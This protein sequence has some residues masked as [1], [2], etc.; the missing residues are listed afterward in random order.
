MPIS[1]LDACRISLGHTR[2]LLRVVRRHWSNPTDVMLYGVHLRLDSEWAT[3]PV[4]G[5]IYDGTYECDE[6]AIVSDTVERDDCVIELGCGSG[7]ISALAARRTANPVSCYDADPA[8]VRVARETLR[9]N[10]AQGTVVNAVM[11]REPAVT[12]TSFYVHRDFWS[13]SLVAVHPGREITVPV[14]DL[15]AVIDEHAAS[16]LILDIEGGETELLLDPLPESVRKVCVE[17][18][19]T[20]SET[21]EITA[22]LQSLLSQGFGLNLERSHPPVLFFAR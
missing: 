5:E 14:L 8:M 22:M 10:K 16:Y 9:L 18:H 13:S 15:V 6:A 3:T 2:E 17:C 19:P 20:V 21:R 1:A 4:R 7:F 11:Q 12:E